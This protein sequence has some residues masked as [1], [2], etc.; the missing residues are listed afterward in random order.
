M[1]IIDIVKIKANAVYR[2][3]KHKELLK[4][5]LDEIILSSF[6]NCANQN[7]HNFGSQNEKKRS[8][9]NKP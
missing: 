9:D 3:Q 6:K 1:F 8:I 7:N 5:N 4:Y 2:L